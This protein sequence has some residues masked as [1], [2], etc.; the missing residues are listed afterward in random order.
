MARFLGRAEAAARL[1]VSESTLDRDRK[2][3]PDHPRPVPFGRRRLYLES[4]IDSYIEKRA[5]ARSEPIAA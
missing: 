4:E 2:A 3:N 1:G 5:A